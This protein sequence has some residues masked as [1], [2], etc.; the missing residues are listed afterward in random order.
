MKNKIWALVGAL[1]LARTVV[2]YLL[3]PMQDEAYYFAWAKNLAWG[4]LDHPPGVAFISLGALL[5]PGSVVFAR[6]GT[7]LLG[8][9]SLAAS[10]LLLRRAGC[11]DWQSLCAGL[12][13]SQASLAG[14]VNGVL[15]TPDVVLGVMWTIA[16]AEAI[17]ALQGKPRHWLGVGAAVGVGLLG[18]YH[19]IL[20]LP[21]LLVASFVARDARNRRLIAT[22]APWLG[23]VVAAALFLPHVVWNAQNDFITMRFQLRHG[24]ELDRTK[25]AQAHLPLPVPTVLG[26]RE[27]DLGRAFTALDP[28]VTPKPPRVTT[29]LERASRNLGDFSGGTLAL[30]GALLFAL[31]FAAVDAFRSRQR[32]RE[33]SPDQ[34]TNVLLIAATVLP[35]A[36]FGL[37]AL[38]TKVEAN[39]AGVHVVGLSALAAP[40]LAKR[41]GIALGSG[42][43]NVALVILATLH[44]AGSLRFDSKG[45]PDRILKETAGYEELANWI[46]YH[47]LGKGLD[48]PLPLFADSYQITSQLGFHAPAIKLMQWPGITRPSEFTRGAHWYGEGELQLATKDGF[49]IITTDLTPPRIPGFTPAA[50]LQLRF[51]LPN[52]IEVIDESEVQSAVPSCA[53]PLRRWQ[54]ISYQPVWP[55]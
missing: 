43:V 7:V 52:S 8:I 24:L 5:S 15:T 6:A 1:V 34:A 49:Q 3:P 55:T 22:P 37:F 21:I 18:K 16:L 9:A 46:E 41:M 48:V 44:A 40:W 32:T 23:L 25:I 12:L 26:S 31:A 30:H 42:A 29:A 20:M 13:V 17:P 36:F 14:M 10:V 35:V 27:A 53:K 38:Q 39:W 54:L 47:R 4:Y 45:R 2:A 50:M 51:C 11:R 28:L 33:K 19:M